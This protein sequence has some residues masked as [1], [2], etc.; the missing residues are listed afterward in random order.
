MEGK[1]HPAVLNRLA[2][3][4][5]YEERIELAR[6]IESLVAHTGFQALDELIEEI[7]LRGFD[8]LANG[9]LLDDRDLVRRLGV[10]NG[11][12][13]HRDA[14]ASVIESAKTAVRDLK[15]TADLE[16]AAGGN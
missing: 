13:F 8:S 14:V 6:Q 16:Q 10:Q 11:M 5:S 3:T 12:A 7:R 15:K 4:R 2:A 1:S 9:S